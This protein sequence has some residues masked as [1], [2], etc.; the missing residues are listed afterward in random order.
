MTKHYQ[1]YRA[2]SL[3]SYYQSLLYQENPFAPSK[4]KAKVNT[5]TPQYEK[6]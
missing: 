1:T 6:I 5:T 4:F 2:Q 3:S